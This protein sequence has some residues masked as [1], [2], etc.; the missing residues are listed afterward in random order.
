MLEGESLQAAFKEI[1]PQAFKGTLF[2][3]VSL[4]A[5]L[6]LVKDATGKLLITRQNPDFLYA[7]GRVIGGGRLTPKGGLARCISLKLRIQQ[8][9][10]NDRRTGSARS[11]DRFASELIELS[12]RHNFVL[13]LAHAESYRGWARSALGNPVEGISWIEQGI[14]DYPR[15]TGYGAGPANSS[16][17]QG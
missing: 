7:G 6:G 5:L 9:L 8:S 2:R 3:C 10:K 13:W 15:A 4:R 11:E 16:R 14:R 1:S 17:S 12:A